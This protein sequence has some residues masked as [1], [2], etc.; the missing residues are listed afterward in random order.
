MLLQ[1]A[2]LLAFVHQYFIL[3]KCMYKRCNLGLKIY[4]Y[5][6]SNVETTDDDTSERGLVFKDSGPGTAQTNPTFQTLELWE[7]LFGSQ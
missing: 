6:G 5:F 7:K 3:L 4:T 2:Y 1:S